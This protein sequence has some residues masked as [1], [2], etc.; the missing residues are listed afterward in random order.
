MGFL[1]KDCSY[2]SVLKMEEKK[3]LS[4]ISAIVKLGE[5]EILAEL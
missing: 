2:L 3:Y 4:E 1:I 5:I